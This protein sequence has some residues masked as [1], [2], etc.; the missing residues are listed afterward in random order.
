MGDFHVALVSIP[1]SARAD[2]LAK[3]IPWKTLCNVKAIL[4]LSFL[5]MNLNVFSSFSATYTSVKKWCIVHS[6]DFSSVVFGVR[7]FYK[8]MLD[9]ITIFSRDNR[10]PSPYTNACTGAPCIGGE[11]RPR[12]FA[13][14]E[15]SL[16]RDLWRRWSAI[17]LKT[18]CQVRGALGVRTRLSEAHRGYLPRT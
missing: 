8:K 15:G 14:E 16:S 12:E 5:Q 13:R 6:F 4:L 3:V 11:L 7:L 17:F 2:C 1:F 9:H 10:L 18:P